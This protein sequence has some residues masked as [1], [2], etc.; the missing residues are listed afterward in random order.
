MYCYNESICQHPLLSL[1]LVSVQLFYNERIGKLLYM[2][3]N[4]YIPSI[5]VRI[6][7]RKWEDRR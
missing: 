1:E 4:N 5:Y 7:I 3:Q 6:V 2:N